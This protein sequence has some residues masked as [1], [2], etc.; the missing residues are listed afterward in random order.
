MGFALAAVPLVLVGVF[1]AS[2]DH[3]KGAVRFAAPLF[4]A[5][6]AVSHPTP[7]VE[8]VSKDWEQAEPAARVKTPE[9][10]GS[11]K[12]VP[13]SF[14]DPL[15]WQAELVTDAAGQAQLEIPLPD[16]VANWHI[17]VS[18]VSARGELGSARFPLRVTLSQ[19]DNAVPQPR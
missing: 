12:R 15:L 19:R 11:P 14:R 6:P 9:Q 13:G 17:A 10:R 7:P 1:L 18:A 2:A 5:A 8:P 16:S 4:G 3:P